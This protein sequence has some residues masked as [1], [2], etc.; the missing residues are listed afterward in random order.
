MALPLSIGPSDFLAAV[1]LSWRV[2]KACKNGGKSFQNI[3]Q[4]VASLYMLLKEGEEIL[5]DRELPNARQTSL[6]MSYVACKSVLEDLQD[7]LRRYQGLSL[8]HRH[9]WDSLKW[10]TVDLKELRLRMGNCR[11]ALQH[12][13]KYA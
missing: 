3:K 9:I 7:L 13:I 2:Y 1:Q 4:E 6:R 10:D 8:S 11:D 12:D 5:F